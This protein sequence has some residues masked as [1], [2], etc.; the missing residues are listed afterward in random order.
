MQELLGATLPL[1]PS[2]SIA[3]IRT[4]VLYF[5]YVVRYLLSDQSGPCYLTVQTIVGHFPDC[6][7]VGSSVPSG[8]C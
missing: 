7:S 8:K 3:Y 6:A 5:I 2:A 4:A 1:P